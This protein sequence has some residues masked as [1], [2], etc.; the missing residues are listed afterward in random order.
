MVTKDSSNPSLRLS[1]ATVAAVE[2]AEEEKGE[3]NA[4]TNL[5]DPS[6]PEWR[7][8]TDCENQE[9]FR[10]LREALLSLP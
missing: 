9:Y 2:T 10:R 8:K 1:M 4:N 3:T 7:D 5:K 6:V